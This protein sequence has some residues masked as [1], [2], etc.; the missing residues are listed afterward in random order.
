MLCTTQCTGYYRKRNVKSIQV[1]VNT[2]TNLCP[3]SHFLFLSLRRKK[4]IMVVRGLH[5]TEKRWA[6]GCAGNGKGRN[7]GMFYYRL[8]FKSF[9]EKSLQ[10]KQGHLGVKLFYL[11]ALIFVTFLFILLYIF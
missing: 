6:D 8:E 9:R 5:F 1:E 11:L 10:K 4:Q 7:N 2:E 3:S